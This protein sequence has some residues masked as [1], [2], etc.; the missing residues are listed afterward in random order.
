MKIGFFCNEYPPR[1]HGGIGT[2]VHVI[3]T[4]LA[5]AGHVVTVVEWGE[6]ASE[7]HHEG[8]RIV[9]LPQ[10][11]TPRIAWLINRLRL[12]RWL[13]GEARARRIEIFEIPEYQGPLPFPLAGCPVVVRLHLSESHIRSIMGG[14]RGKAYWLEKATLFWHR[15]WI[16]VSRYILDET[17]RFFGLEPRAAAVIYNPAPAIHLGRIPRVPVLPQRYIVYVGSVSERKGALLL[18]EAMQSLFDQHPDIRLVYVGPET[19]YRGKPISVAIRARL[20]E[21]AARVIITGRVPHDEALAW[22]RGATALVLVSK[23]EAFPIVPLEAMTLGVPVILA[24]IAPGPEL[25]EHEVSGLLVHPDSKDK[26]TQAI[27]RVL[28]DPQAAQRMAAAG[29]KKVMTAYTVGYCLR[30]SIGFYRTA[31]RGDS[32]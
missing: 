19:E 21:H 26:L 32:R 1:P 10:S 6:R 23:V 17:R 8:V 28:D 4:A 5:Q 29:Q 24:D 3:A 18:A 30:E 27:R 31:L 13:R 11:D 15:R 9:T 14:S 25:V 16:G 7:T 2:F 12:W 20:G 22:I